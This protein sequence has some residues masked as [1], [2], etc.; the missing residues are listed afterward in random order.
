MS[1][2]PSTFSIPAQTAALLFE[3]SARATLRRNAPLGMVSGSVGGNPAEQAHQAKGPFWKIA[4]TKTKK[5][6]CARATEA[7]R[8]EKRRKNRGFPRGRATGVWSCKTAQEVRP[9]KTRWGRSRGSKRA[10][11]KCARRLGCRGNRNSMGFVPSRPSSCSIVCGPA[12]EPIAESGRH[13]G[14]PW[15]GLVP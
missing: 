6:V 11:R 5:P 7:R 13:R 9:K 12:R 14:G 15:I 4:K 2:F 8:C 10:S 3:N 1:R